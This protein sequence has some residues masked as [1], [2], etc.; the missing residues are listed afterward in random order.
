MS[1]GSWIAGLIAAHDLAVSKASLF[2][3][4][5]SLAKTCST[6]QHL[7]KTRSDEKT[8]NINDN[9]VCCGPA[10]VGRVSRSARSILCGRRR[11]RVP[12][13]TLTDLTVNSSFGLH[14]V[15]D[16][17]ALQKRGFA[18]VL[19]C[20]RDRAE[21]TRQQWRW[22]M[23]KHLATIDRLPPPDVDSWLASSAAQSATW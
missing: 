7:K 23:T 22:K 12:W 17:A 19:S 3:T 8:A 1:L 15:H 6:V 4:A 10:A 5:G 21:D 16:P 2:L 20:L 14:F 18:D 9:K 13:F 11:G